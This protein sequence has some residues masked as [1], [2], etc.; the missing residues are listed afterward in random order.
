MLYIHLFAAV[1]DSDLVWGGCSGSKYIISSTKK[2]DF[3]PFIDYDLRVGIALMVKT[4]V[5]WQEN[6][7]VGTTKL[8]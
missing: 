5:T 2:L 6:K 8:Y 1:V 7:Y 3:R 4:D